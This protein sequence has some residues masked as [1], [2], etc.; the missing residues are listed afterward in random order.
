MCVCVCD[1]K[2]LKQQRI[3]VLVWCRICLD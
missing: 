2:S 3:I 1:L